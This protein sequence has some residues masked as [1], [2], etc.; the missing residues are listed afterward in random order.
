MIVSRYECQLYSSNIFVL[1]D[2]KSDYCWLVDIGEKGFLVPNGKRVKGVFITH[3]HID[4]IQGINDLLTIYPDCMVYVNEAGRDGLY[5]DKI[6]LTFY[7]GEPL[8]FV[9]GD[10]RITK[11]GD[12]VQLFEGLE[13]E[14]I[15]TPGHHPS[16][17][18]F[19]A[20]NYLFSGDSYIPGV[21]VV[22]KLKGGN[23]TQAEESEERIKSL[24]KENTMLCPGHGDIKKELNTIDGKAKRLYTK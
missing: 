17:I 16:C 7:H 14:I 4:H 22:T 24:V 2:V 3:T 20:G 1:E 12:K 6:N 18:C 13:M 8:C 5:N 23:R 21:P 15:E 11:E 10:V 19:K 9:G